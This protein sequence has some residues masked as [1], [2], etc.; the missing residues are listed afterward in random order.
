MWRTQRRYKAVLAGLAMLAASVACLSPSPDVTPGVETLPPPGGEQVSPVP[1]ATSPPGMGSGQMGPDTAGLARA[2][3]QILA[4]SDAG[5]QFSPVWTGSG[6]IISPDGLILTNGHVVDDRSGKWTHLG[7]LITDRTDEPPEFRYLAEIAAVD[8]DLDLA[9]I[10]IVSDTEGNAVSL[11]LPYVG[12]GDSDTVE[13]GENLRIL[14]YPGIGGE[15]ITFTEGAVSGFTSE[16]GV[17]GRA[18]IKTDATVAGGNSGGMAVGPSGMLVG[19][20]TRASLGDEDPQIV[21]CRPVADTNRDG[22]VDDRDTCVPIGGFINGLRPIN[23]A[24]AVIEAA[25]AGRQYVAGAGPGPAPPGGYDLSETGFLNLLFSDGVTEDDRPT[26]IWTAMP[27]G[28]TDVCAFWD[29]EG[30][31]D[32][33]TWSAYWFVGGELSEGASVLNDAWF[34]GGAGNWWVCIFNENGL[35]DGL[36]ELS[37]EVEGEV[38]VSESIFVGLDRYGVDF[39][40]ANESSFTVCYV[41]FSPSQA[42]GWGQDELGAEEVI[43]A[44]TSRTFLL[45]N[46]DYDMRLLDCDVNLL[47]EEYGIQVYEDFVFTLTD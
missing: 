20:P 19:V 14:G 22:V 24:F 7:V 6:S 28:V 29:Y 35:P 46:G 11:E 38:M 2:A 26:Q 5:G 31:V 47:L 13:I 33:M 44:G 32:G 30:M 12:I 45:A 37:L 18:W 17:E 4:L 16:R 42:Q 43:N 8:Y 40:L 27:T 1:V 39:T 3:V 36:Y 41:Q 23:L 34:G 21:D 15:T 25:R 9:V 10:R